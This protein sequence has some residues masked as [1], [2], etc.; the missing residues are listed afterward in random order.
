M[1]GLD[2]VHAGARRQSPALLTLVC[3]QQAVQLLEVGHDVVFDVWD[4]NLQAN[5]AAVEGSG[6][7]VG[8][9]LTYH[10]GHH[11]NDL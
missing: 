10:P 4:G 2:N 9:H 1:Q 7:I 3:L 8:K 6:V 5:A 11:R